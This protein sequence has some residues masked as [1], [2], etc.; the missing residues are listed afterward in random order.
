M[1]VVR[2]QGVSRDDRAIFTCGNCGSRT[3]KLV[4]QGASLIARIECANCEDLQ[5]GLGQI[6]GTGEESE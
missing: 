5:L 3:F 4:R 6:Q 2:F 1:T